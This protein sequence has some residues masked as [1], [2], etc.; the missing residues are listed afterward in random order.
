MRN[1]CEDRVRQQ[2]RQS[3]TPCETLGCETLG[4][5]DETLA[6]PRLAPRTDIASYWIIIVV[7]YVAT[8]Y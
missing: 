4:C 8:T 7:Y 1:G 6:I 2:A 3:D 5:V